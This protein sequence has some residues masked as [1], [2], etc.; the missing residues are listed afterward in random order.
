MKM[1]SVNKVVGLARHLGVENKGRRDALDNLD[2]QSNQ[3]HAFE[4]GQRAL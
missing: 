1:K 2:D 4:L 3:M